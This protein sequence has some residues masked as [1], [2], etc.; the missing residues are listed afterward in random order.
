[1]RRAAKLAFPLLA[2]GAALAAGLYGAGVQTS[3]PVAAAASIAIPAPARDAGESGSRAVAVLAGGCFWGVEG[4]YEHVEG[5]ISVEAG[6]AGGTRADATYEQVSRGRTDHAEAVRI[7][8]DPRRISY[9]QLLHI[10]FSVAHDPTQ[11]NRQGP[12]VGRHYR[13]AIFPQN[14]QQ[15]QAASAYIAQL[16]ASRSFRGSIVTRLES[17]GF[18]PA[19]AYHQNFMRRNPTH[20]YIVMHDAPKLRDLRASFPRLFSSRPAA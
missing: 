10:F 8:Y 4:V 9:G 12:D 17:G 19:E 15:R 5:V 14:A 6:Y 20:G 18:W 16:G 3:A 1:M 11:L 2:G 13:S 7:T